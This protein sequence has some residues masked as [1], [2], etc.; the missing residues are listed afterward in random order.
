MTVTITTT[1]HEGGVHI[2]EDDWIDGGMPR[3]S[4][5]SPWT[6]ASPK[7]DAIIRRQG[8]LSE[9]FVREV[10][11]ELVRYLEPVDDG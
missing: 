10:V 7:H 1:P 11:K 4:Y 3:K 5:A 9:T 6:V 8:R 2:T